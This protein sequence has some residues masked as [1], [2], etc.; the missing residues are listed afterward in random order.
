MCVCVVFLGLP[1]FKGFISVG[2]LSLKSLMFA[3][4]ENLSRLCGV[5]KH[6]SSIA[7]SGAKRSPDLVSSEHIVRNTYVHFCFFVYLLCVT[8]LRTWS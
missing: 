2:P 8:G 7:L 5:A 6:K 1:A 4:Y 3:C